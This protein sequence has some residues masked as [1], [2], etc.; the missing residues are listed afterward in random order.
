MMNG[1]LLDT[2]VV[3]KAINKDSETIK[4]L[5]EMKKQK[6]FV[7]V[8]TIGELAYGASKSNMK[9]QNIRLFSDFIDSRRILNA[10]E[11]SALIYGEVKNGL[12][13]KG[14]NIPENDM[15]I[16]AVA[17]ANDLKLV[18][19]DNHFKEIENLDALVL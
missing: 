7:S 10:D 13:S 6:I 14:V 4:I 19:F 16:A 17:I 5:E 12:K 11:K 9:K 3:I 8:I 15:W 1:N 18:T 2:N